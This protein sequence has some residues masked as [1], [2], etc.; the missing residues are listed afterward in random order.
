MALRACFWLGRMASRAHSSGPTARTMS[1]S[2]STV[3]SA[4]GLESLGQLIDGV[5]DLRQHFFGQVRVKGGSAGTVM[6][7]NLLDDAQIDSGFQQMSGISVAQ[8]LLILHINYLRAE[9][10]T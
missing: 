3:N 9:S 5:L 4:G 1:A 7:Q 6:A 2:S 10:N 8:R